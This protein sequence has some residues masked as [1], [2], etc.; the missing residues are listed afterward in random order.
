MRWIVATDGKLSRHAQTHPENLRKDAS[1]NALLQLLG[2]DGV[3]ELNETWYEGEKTTSEVSAG[4]QEAE[5][6]H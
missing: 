4:A 3:I 2:F 1:D 5:T 6:T